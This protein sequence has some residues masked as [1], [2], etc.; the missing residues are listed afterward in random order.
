MFRL[1]PNLERDCLKLGE[2]PLSLLLLHRDANYPWCILVPQREAITE[3]YQLAE[4]DM[5]QFTAESR[6][7]SRV[8]MELFGGDKLNVAALG[9]Q[10]PQ[11]HVHHIVR[12]RDDG[13][14][15]GPVWGAL[16]ASKQ[17][18]V[19]DQAKPSL[20]TRSSVLA[21]RSQAWRTIGSSAAA[22]AG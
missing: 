7:L 21:T 9:N 13:A 5:S 6:L 20:R 16:P 2:F 12:F 3:L 17:R 4:R 19:R 8:M 18:R 10:V 11:L 22:R 14:W 1:D 15:P